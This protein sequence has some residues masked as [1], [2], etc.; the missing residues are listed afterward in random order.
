MH[1][2][3]M[4]RA[5]QMLALV[6]LLVGSAAKEAT[7][8]TTSLALVESNVGAATSAATFTVVLDEA[9]AGNVWY[10]ARFSAPAPPCTF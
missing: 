4:P 2:P 7:L 3:T 1:M 6:A 9:P 5:L 10:A 8:S